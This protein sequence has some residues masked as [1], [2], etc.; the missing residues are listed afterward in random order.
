MRISFLKLIHVFFTIVFSFPT[1]KVGDRIFERRMELGMEFCLG[2][3]AL[4][5]AGLVFKRERSRRLLDGTVLELLKQSVLPWCLLPLGRGTVLHASKRFLTT[6][7]CS[8]AFQTLIGSEVPSWEILSKVFQQSD[9]SSFQTAVQCVLQYGTPVVCSLQ[10]SGQPYTLHL[11]LLKN[12][13]EKFSFFKTF[14]SLCQGLLLILEESSATIKTQM[15]CAQ[16]TQK[17]RVCLAVLDALPF[18]VWTRDSNGQLTF[19][20]KAYAKELETQQHKVLSHQWELIDGTDARSAKELYRKVLDTGETQNLCVH[21]R[22]KGVLKTFDLTEIPLFLSPGGFEEKKE[23]R[24]HSELSL[25]SSCIIVGTAV[26]HSQ[27]VRE[28]KETK[29][30]LALFQAIIGE[31]GI[32][33]CIFDTKGQIIACNAAS[34]SLSAASVPRSPSVLNDLFELLREHNQLPDYIDFAK[35]RQMGHDWCIHKNVPYHD[36]WYLPSGRAIDLHV[37]AFQDKT[38]VLARDVSQSL[39]LE[40]N[41]RLLRAVWD[42]SVEQAPDA[43]L[44]LS[45]DHRIQKCSQALKSLLD[46]EPTEWTGRPIKEFLEALSRQENVQSFQ[47]AMEDAI[48]LRKPRKT[49]ITLSARLM[50]CAYTPLPDGSHRLSFFPE[51]TQKGAETFNTNLQ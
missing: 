20:N 10:L 50:A 42:L 24:G 21:K 19:C 29:D 12:E 7:V 46:F 8:N 23:E 51:E 34:F 16:A 17:V 47:K 13:S 39:A 26:D 43:L 31:F 22:A 1:L 44:V 2:G 28:L 6:G 27:L 4:G 25:S 14:P 3:L 37:K 11:S 18:P 33:F 35:V 30:E 38:I 5:V 48:E 9:P 36:L 45:Q 40:R 15:E 41:Y 49:S 32:P